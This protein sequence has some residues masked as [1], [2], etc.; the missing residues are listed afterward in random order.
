MQGGLVQESPII[1]AL[2]VIE[3]DLL[4]RSIATL[5][6]ENE[7]FGNLRALV[8]LEVKMVA[9]QT[10]PRLSCHAARLPPTEKSP[11][12]KHKVLG[13]Y[14]CGSKYSKRSNS[15]AH[16]NVPSSFGKT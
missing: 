12:S 3:N 6:F 10:L 15:N 7:L 14:V 16:A 5:D 13:L 8:S 2:R 9:V 11:A 1:V 4:A